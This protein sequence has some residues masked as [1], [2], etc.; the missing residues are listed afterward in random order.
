MS[1]HTHSNGILH[2]TYWPL[3]APGPGV[4]GAK[5]ARI[6]ATAAGLPAKAVRSAMGGTGDWPCVVSSVV[7]VARKKAREIALAASLRITLRTR[8]LAASFV[9]AGPPMLV[10]AVCSHSQT[11]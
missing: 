1:K 6:A 4:A 3:P 9:C 8:L 10:K 11:T 7:S 5:A 2:P